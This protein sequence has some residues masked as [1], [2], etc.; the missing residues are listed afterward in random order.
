MWE[1]LLKKLGYKSYTNDVL[2]AESEVA[3]RL[4]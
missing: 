4:Y 2:L 3:L 1:D